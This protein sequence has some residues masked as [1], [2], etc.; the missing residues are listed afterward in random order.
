MRKKGEK[1]HSMDLYKEL[2]EIESSISD[3]EFEKRLKFL[4]GPRLRTA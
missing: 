4:I 2:T 3:T 1:R